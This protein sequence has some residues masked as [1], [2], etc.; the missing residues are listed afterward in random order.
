M[1]DSILYSTLRSL[2]IAFGAVLGIILGIFLIL[3][4]VGAL[5]TGSTEG[6][7]K[8]TNT[9]EILPNAEGKRE[10]MAKTVPVILQIN[11]DGIIGLSQLDAETIRQ[12]LIES[13][14][15]KL[16]DDRVKAIL[17]Y[18]DS[19]GGTVTDADGIYRALVAYKHKYKVPIYAYINGLC[20]SGGMYVASA[21]D[22]IFANE[23]SLIGSVGVLAPTFVNVT[24]L[25]DKLGVETLTITAGKEKD[26]LNPLRPWKPGEDKNYREIID[27]YY[28]HFVDIVTSS[29]PEINRDKLIQDYGAHVFSAPDALKYGFIDA[30]HSSLSQTIKELLKVI[31]VEG[32]NYQVVKLESKQWWNTVFSGDSARALKTGVIKHQ[33]QLSP[34]LDFTLQNKFL[35]LY[36]P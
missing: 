33:I 32:N 36:R 26:A 28:N 2:A 17:L 18:I 10:A 19:P 3:V 30:D 31:G 20:A 24:K 22:K 21:A 25:L 34:D 23:V 16:K 14:E 1:R 13:R 8:M 5:S 15:G 29:R 27:Y 6:R 7:I 11:L 9:E 12:Q 35:Y 4:I